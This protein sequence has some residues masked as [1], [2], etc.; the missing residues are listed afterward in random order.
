MGLG[1]YILLTGLTYLL[2][3]LI[4]QQLRRQDRFWIFTGWTVTAS[5]LC[6][7][8]FGA[9]SISIGVMQIGVSQN[10]NLPQ[11]YFSLGGTGLVVLLI[12]LAGILAPAWVFIILEK[13]MFTSSTDKTS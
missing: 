10:F 11:N 5:L 1:A 9:L 8:L 2:I 7:A 4:K 3:L 13:R 12:G 6:L